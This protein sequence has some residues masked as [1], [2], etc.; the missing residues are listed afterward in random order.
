MQVDT[1]NQVT[2]ISRNIWELISKPSLQNSYLYLK[3]FDGIVIK[4]FYGNLKQHSKLNLKKYRKSY[5][6]RL[7]KES[8]INWHGC[9]ED[10]C[11]KLVV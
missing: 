7:Y 5:C 9:V 1:S 3:Q 4:V 2:I 8:Q 11:N 10:K 6:C